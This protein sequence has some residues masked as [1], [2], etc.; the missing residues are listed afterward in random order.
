M[1]SSMLAALIG[2]LG[3]RE[4]SIPH[5]Q[6]AFPGDLEYRGHGETRSRKIN[7]GTKPKF[8]FMRRWGNGFGEFL[9]LHTNTIE[10]RKIR[11]EGLSFH[12]RVHFGIK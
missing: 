4:P 1:K 12:A 10:V 6:P 11:S 2:A 9:N 5:A 3:F 8:R 7:Q